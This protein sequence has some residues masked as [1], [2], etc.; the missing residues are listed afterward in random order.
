VDEIKG[1]RVLSIAPQTMR[2]IPVP[3]NPYE[4]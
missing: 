2:P 1:E 4:F 3:K